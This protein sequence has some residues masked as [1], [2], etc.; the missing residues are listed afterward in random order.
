MSGGG[1]LGKTAISVRLKYKIMKER[2]RYEI[3]HA[4]QFYCA[5]VK[6]RSVKHIKK[7]NRVLDIFNYDMKVSRSVMETK[8]G[9]IGTTWLLIRFTDTDKIGNF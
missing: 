8:S 9:R 1:L 7:E 5:K 6:N 4:K 2:L 3:L